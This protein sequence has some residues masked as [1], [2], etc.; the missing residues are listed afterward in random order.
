MRKH[1]RPHPQAGDHTRA[2]EVVQAT[3]LALAPDV[4][5]AKAAA[6]TPAAGT[7]IEVLQRALREAAEQ[8]DGLTR[9]LAERNAQFN[10]LIS[11]GVASGGAARELQD[12]RRRVAAQAEALQRRESRRQVHDALLRD[13]QEQVDERDVEIVRLLGELQAYAQG[14]SSA[15]RPASAWPDGDEPTPAEQAEARIASLASELARLHARAA[16][17]APP[18]GGSPPPAGAPA[19]AQSPAPADQAGAAAADDVLKAEISALRRANDRLRGEIAEREA[20]QADKPS[21]RDTGT[22]AATSDFA[23]GAGS[24]SFAL[25]E[26]ELRMFV[27]TEGDAG[28]VHVLGRRTTMGRTP[29]NDLCIE[30]ESVSRHHA[31]ALQT[32]G[33]TVIEDLNSTNGVFVNGHRVSRRVLMAGDLVTIGT[34]SFRFLVKPADEAANS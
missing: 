24:G 16:A 13:Y 28:I 27:R 31:V 9:Q 29:D 3:E 20:R 23:S 22:F 33:G 5:P 2:S 8:V 14:G 25:A 26:G 4:A 32:P 30:S 1:P 18:P 19:P 10:A 11:G 7:G 21:P 15:A 17:F 12:L 6:A 34:A